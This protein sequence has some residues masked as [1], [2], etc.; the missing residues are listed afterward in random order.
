MPKDT[1]VA[2]LVAFVVLA[3]SDA[4]ALGRLGDTDNYVQLH[5]FLNVLSPTG[6]DLS[7]YDAK[8]LQ[9]V[10][11]GIGVVAGINVSKAHKVPLYLEVGANFGLAFEKHIRLEDVM[12]VDKD[13]S[14][15]ISTHEGKH[16]FTDRYR[17]FD[18]AIPIDVAYRFSLADGRVRIKPLLGLNLRINILNNKVTEWWALSEV[19]KVNVNRLSTNEFEGVDNPYRRF[20]VGL[21]AGVDFTF[22]RRLCIGYHICPDLSPA[23][24]IDASDWKVKAGTLHQII[25]LGVLF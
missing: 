2:M 12:Y 20:Q 22:A 14:G 17:Y 7:V 18:I 9:G 10:G 4:G 3:T 13:L 25:C 16:D 15:R 21:T 8:T 11:P 24:K 23:F 1:K 19:N 6:D 5:T